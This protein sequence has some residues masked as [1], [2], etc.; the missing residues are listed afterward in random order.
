MDLLPTADQ[1]DMM[2]TVEQFIEK[3]LPASLRH[4]LVDAAALPEPDL[5]RGA[6]ELGIFALGLPEQAGGADC[7]IV[8]EALIF[9]VL[10]RHLAPVGFLASVLATRLAEA[11]GDAGLRDRIA[12]GEQRVALALPTPDGGADVFDLDETMLV[13]AAGEPPTLSAAPNTLGVQAECLDPSVRLNHLPELTGALSVA[14]ETGRGTGQLGTLLAA[15]QLVGI[16]EA[17]RDASVAHARDRVQ[18]GRP[19]GTNQAIKH[20]CADMAVSA[21]AAASL[22]RFAALALR[23]G[24]EDA[25]FQVA[26]AKRMATAAA[27]DNAR[28]NVQIHGGMGY[29]WEHDAHL[30]L[31]RAHVLDQLFGN[32]RAQQRVMLGTAPAVP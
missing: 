19:I 6:A 32:V 10:G 28:A 14:G 31:S 16:A 13:V 9:Q 12:A 24:R 2:A 25:A 29:T 20:R 23:D 3:E 26:A 27:I 17:A 11:H 4:R 21:E 15:A 22:L 8:E 1:V 5:W 7:P 18:F 30:L